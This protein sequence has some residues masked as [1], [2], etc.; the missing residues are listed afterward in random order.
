MLHDAQ[1]TMPT[2]GS[3]PWMDESAF[4]VAPTTTSP[5]GYLQGNKPIPCSYTELVAA[6]SRREG[7]QIALVWTPLQARLTPPAE[8]P[9]L[10]DALLTQARQ[11][12]RTGLW[13][14]LFQGVWWGWLLFLRSTAMNAS[15]QR[16]TTYLFYLIAFS[17]IPL[18]EQLW[19]LWRLRQGRFDPLT[20]IGTARFNAWLGRQSTPWPWLLCGCITVV[21]LVQLMVGFTHLLDDSWSPIARAGLV[22][23]EVWAGAWWRLL[24]GPLLHGNVIHFALNVVALLVLAK[25]SAVFL[26]GW[27]TV[28]TFISGALLGSVA[29]LLWTTETSVGASGGILGLLGVLIALGV[30]QRTLLP[31]AIVRSLLLTLGLVAV[32]GFIA[33]QV[34]DNGAHAGG[35]LAGLALGWWWGRQPSLV[36]PLPTDRA[37]RSIGFLALALLLLASGLAIVVMLRW[38]E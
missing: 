24:T 36:I 19:T 10:S 29:S 33:A 9:F 31:P 2:P 14:S 12:A 1:P 21:G 6:I 32:T 7:Q 38:W 28:I 11:V 26:G 17:L 8:V 27:R 37:T 30:R 5:Y 15:S 34:I 23:P 20:Q 16:S 13:Y 22:K 25:I 4:P 18:V 3:M 35:V